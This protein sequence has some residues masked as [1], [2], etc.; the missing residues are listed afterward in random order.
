VWRAT[1]ALTITQALG[2]TQAQ[3]AEYLILDIAASNQAGAPVGRDAS[4]ERLGPPELTYNGAISYEGALGESWNWRGALDY[5]YRSDTDPPLLKPL[6][7][8][9][10]G[11]PAYWLV[12][13]NVEL[14]PAASDWSF[15]LWG[16]N[17]L[18]EDYDETRNFFAGT[19]WTPISAP[20]QPATYGVRLSFRH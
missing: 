13:A 19:D 10:Y 8:E 5:S 20:G 9:G 6:S 1:D 16:R 7:G 14:A 18:D 17:I 15:A 4:G 2:Y 12:N 11:V 3:F